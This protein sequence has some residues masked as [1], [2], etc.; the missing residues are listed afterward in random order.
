LLGK[1]DY[2]LFPKEL[3]DKY[4]RDD[5]RVV[6]SG[7]MFEDIEE[8]RSGDGQRLYVHVL[9]APVR[10]AQAKVVGTQ[11][12]FWDVTARK[13]A[14]EALEKAAAELA[15]S[16]KELEQFAYVASHDLQE[17][18]RMITSYTQL[19]AKRYQ[20]KL[21]ADAKDFMQ[22]AVDGA[23]RMQKLIQGLLLYSRVG[24]RGKPFEP[25]SC[26]EC[27]T[28]G[29]ANLKI[30]I[31][32]S[33]ADIQMPGEALPQVMGDAIQLTQLFQNLLG[34]SLKFRNSAA[35]VIQIAAERR[36]R[37]DAATLNVPPY[38][39][40]FH[41]SDNGIGIE[42]QYFE[43]IFVIFQRLHTQD[44]YPGTGIGLAICR[45]IVERHGGRIWL[46][47]KPGLGTTFHFTLPALD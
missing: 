10:D 2:Q 27:L 21:D 16:N 22:F 23:L 20:G 14:E 47:S 31:H 28:G 38:E 4:C 41:I 8:H 35:L 17:P 18:L 11:I 37:A 26:Q 29:L 7:E 43:R 34:N 44:Q 24:T 3:A 45:K 19:I 6:R 5:E 12:I 39:W 42:P 13:L 25:T 46:D 9:K 30:A 32:E 40:V 36:A 33:G 15:R 1:T